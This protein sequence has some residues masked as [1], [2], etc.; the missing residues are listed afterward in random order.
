MR[1]LTHFVEFKEIVIRLIQ[2][3]CI[4]RMGSI[5]KTAE[6]VIKK[7][8]ATVIPLNVH[9]YFRCRKCNEGEAIPSQLK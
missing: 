6:E 2:K 7:I 1:Q 4:L 3:E 9:F 8:F 5:L